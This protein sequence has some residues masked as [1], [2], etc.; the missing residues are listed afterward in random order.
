[1][2]II[3][4]YVQSPAFFFFRFSC[5]VLVLSDRFSSDVHQSGKRQ[6]RRGHRKSRLRCIQ[7]PLASGEAEYRAEVGLEQPGLR[8]F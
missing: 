1:M 4:K 8:G 7:F 6:A 2:E 5:S 3:D